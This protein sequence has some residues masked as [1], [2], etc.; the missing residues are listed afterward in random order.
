M[1]S[2][3]VFFSDLKYGSCSSVVEARLL[4]DVNDLEGEDVLKSEFCA[5]VFD[6]VWL[7][8]H[9]DEEYPVKAKNGICSEVIALGSF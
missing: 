2:S 5:D 8:Y 4:V 7:C 3:R 6:N 9:I 1:A